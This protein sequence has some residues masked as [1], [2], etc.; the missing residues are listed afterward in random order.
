LR[1]L[2][3]GTSRNLDTTVLPKQAKDLASE[4]TLVGS[5]S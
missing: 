1:S 5:F 2:S 4:V 3:I